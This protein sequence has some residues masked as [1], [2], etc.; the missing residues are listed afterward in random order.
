MEWPLYTGLRK[1]AVL[2][3]SQRY[4]TR[5]ILSERWLAGA[6]SSLLFRAWHP[7]LFFA[8]YWPGPTR[9]S[10]IQGFLPEHAVSHEEREKLP[11]SAAPH[12][13][14]PVYLVVAPNLPAAAAHTCGKQPEKQAPPTAFAQS[15]FH[16]GPHECGRRR[17]C[18]LQALSQEFVYL[19]RIFHGTI[20]V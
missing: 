1:A 2:V 11:L 9:R 20:L 4:Y 10:P 19:I 3:E 13:E 8:F 17:H 6:V 12:E 14:P 5:S 15:R 16:P 7:L 18:I